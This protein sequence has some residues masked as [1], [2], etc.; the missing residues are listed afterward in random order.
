MKKLATLFTCSC[1][2]LKQVRTIT[3]CAMLGA[4]GVALGSVSI[5]ME[6]MRIGF[7]GIPA[8]LAGYLFGPAVGGIFAGALDIIKYLVKPVGA[9]FPGLTLVMALKGVIYGCFFY[10]KPLSLPRVLAAQFVIA[11]VCN[12]ILNTL[13][14]SI[15]SGSTFMALLPPRIIQNL[16]LWPIDTLIFF[17]VAKL[18]EVSGVFRVLGRS[19]VSA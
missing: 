7:A 12:L 2:E 14:L 15:L 4:V 19:R 10:C 17:N 1:E 16:I 9:F 6:N 3:V 11:L 13:C 5:Q 8:M 18:L